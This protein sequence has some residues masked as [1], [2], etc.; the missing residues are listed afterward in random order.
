MAFIYIYILFDHPH[1]FRYPWGRGYHTTLEGCD[2]AHHT[3]AGRLIAPAAGA[4]IIESL[5]NYIIRDF[6]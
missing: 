3:Q 5:I 2:H 6:Y 4:D 1:F